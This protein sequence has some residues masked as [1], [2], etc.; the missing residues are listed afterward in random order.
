MGNAVCPE[1]GLIGAR[2]D[3]ARRN[4]FAAG[5]H[6]AAALGRDRRRIAGARAHGRHG[7]RQPGALPLRGRHPSG[8]PLAQGIQRPALHALNRRAAA[9]RRH[10][11]AGRPAACG[12]RGDHGLRPARRR[13]RDRVRVRLCRGRRRGPR[14]SGTARRSGARRWR[15]DAR[16]QL[17]RHVRLRRRRGADLRVQR[18]APAAGREAEDRRGGAERRDL[19]DHAHGVPRQGARHHVLH[20]DRQRGRPD[21]RRFPRRADRRCRDASGGAVPRTGPPSADVPRTGQARPRT[22]QAGR[23]DASGA[24][25]SARASRPARTP[26]RSRAI[27]RR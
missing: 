19:G 14:R 22:R 26:A 9:R 25:A 11:G 12:G 15:A 17:H 16:P 23:R 13:R 1:L 2:P 5:P 10:C 24:A 3:H 6:P 7:A 4:R 20:L 8:Q 21:R 18:R 27:T